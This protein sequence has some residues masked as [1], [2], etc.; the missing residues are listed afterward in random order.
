VAAFDELF[1][2]YKYMA[3]RTAYLITG[4]KSICED[5]AQDTFIICYNEIGKLR[6]PEGF[7][8][9]FFRILTREAWR[10]GKA[11]SCEVASENVLEE[12]DKTSM[13][14]SLEQ[15]FHADISQSLY[16]EIARLRPKLK[17]IV[18]LYYFSGLT[19]REIATA[20]GCLEGTVKSRLHT[21][22][23]ELKKR[24]ELQG[25]LGKELGDRATHR[26]NR[27]ENQA[28]IVGSR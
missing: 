19:T 20:V 3:V 28:D 4:N 15:H 22:R 6:S 9:W 25:Y 24:L 14:G 26:F 12:L 21:A 1:E 16:T 5:I 11:A 18:V 17:T 10:C 23:Q 13:E 2:K 8:A 27:R 7:R